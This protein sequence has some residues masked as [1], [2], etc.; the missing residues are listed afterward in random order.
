M[1]SGLYSDW[2]TYYNKDNVTG[3]DL[4]YIYYENKMLGVPRLRQ[5]K[6]YY[7]TIALYILHPCILFG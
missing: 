5:L 4:G 1:I 3:D 6:V 2:E 7:L